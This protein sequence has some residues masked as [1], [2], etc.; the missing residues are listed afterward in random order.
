M[1][2]QPLSVSGVILRLGRARFDRRHI[3][4][5]AFAFVEI[6]HRR[7]IIVPDIGLVIVLPIL[8]VTCDRGVRGFRVGK[9]NGSG[10]DKV[11]DGLGAGLIR[12]LMVGVV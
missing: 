4:R 12:G 6:R 1:A 9:R 3:D 2:Q 10:I 5:T 8:R 7:R 11:G